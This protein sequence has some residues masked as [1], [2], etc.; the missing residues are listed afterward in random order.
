MRRYCGCWGAVML[1]TEQE[2]RNLEHRIDELIDLCQ[3]LEEENRA[4][5]SKNSSLLQER[6]KLMEKN[7]TARS[8]VEAMIL[9][10]KT[11]EQSA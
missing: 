4:L 9:R 8:R 10:L 6:S 11:M 7:E 5:R 1:Q 2:F 3:R